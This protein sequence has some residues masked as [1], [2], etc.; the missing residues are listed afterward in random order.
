MVTAEEQAR[1][2]RWTAGTFAVAGVLVVAGW[3][4]L[5][6]PDHRYLEVCDIANVK[7]MVAELGM[8]KT[9]HATADGRI[10]V[11]RTF[12]EAVELDEE[13]AGLMY[14]E[15]ADQGPTIAEIRAGDYRHFVWE[16]ARAIDVEDGDGET[17]WIWDPIPFD[18]KRVVGFA[19]GRV[20]V[21]REEEFAALSR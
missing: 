21:V 11:F 9:T 20:E 14:H 5:P 16:R 4:L 3:V 8:A 19:N 7:Q 2:V 12:F 17:P 10:D 15:R 1:V 6:G 18:G 13:N